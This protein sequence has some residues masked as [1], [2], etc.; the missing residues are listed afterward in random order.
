MREHDHGAGQGGRQDQQ[1]RK[2]P[3]RFGVQVRPGP[4]GDVPHPFDTTGELDVDHGGRGQQA[5]PQSVQARDTKVW[6]G[7]RGDT[8]RQCFDDQHVG[9]DVPRRRP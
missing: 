4:A 9:E 6:C 3:T 1:G 5:E 8:E 7:G 2:R